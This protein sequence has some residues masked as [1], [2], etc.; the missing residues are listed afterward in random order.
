[1]TRASLHA[2]TTPAPLLLCLAL[3]SL[4]N[5]P[6]R[7]LAEPILF[8]GFEDSGTRGWSAT[9]PPTCTDGAQ[10]GD[11]TGVDCGGSLCADCSLVCPPRDFGQIGGPCDS[12]DD[13]GTA[14]SAC[15]VGLMG[16]TVFAPE[17]YCMVDDYSLSEGVCTTGADC[18][19]GTICVEWLDLPGYRSCMPACTCTGDGC[20]EHQ[21]CRNSFHGF[22][23]DSA[24]CTPGRAGALDG[25]ACE[26]FFDCDEYSSCLDD[27]EYPGGECERSDCIVGDDT[28][29]N[30]GHCVVSD[31]GFGAATTCVDLCT[32]DGDCRSGEG[33][34]CYDPD[35]AGTAP[36]FCRHPHVGDPC[37]SATD[38]GGG[39]WSCKTGSGFVDGLCTLTAC[40]TP[41]SPAGCTDGSVCYDDLLGP[42]NYCVDR[43]TG[44]GQGSCRTGYLCTDTA[45]G[46]GVA[47]GCVPD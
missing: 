10:T 3:V 4:Q 22:R 2:S 8:D 15:Y 28:T 35:G 37:V 1:M 9:V 31:P 18:E 23:L 19:A 17:G 32:D 36:D 43:C 40:P 24:V 38:C 39:S 33:Y 7:L 45:P 20:P 44:G 30:G 6:L 42:E 46:G 41:G 13:C 14:D 12:S 25:E 21:A 34:V 29:C 27:A 16:D 11:E 47:L 26:G 5:L